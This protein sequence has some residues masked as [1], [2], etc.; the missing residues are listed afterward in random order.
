[1]IEAGTCKIV[2]SMPSAGGPVKTIAEGDYLR[3]SKNGHIP[4]FREGAA[5]E[6]QVLPRRLRSC[7]AGHAGPDQIQ[8]RTGIYPEPHRQNHQP[9][10][11]HTTKRRNNEGLE[12]A[13][14]V[15]MLA[16]RDRPQINI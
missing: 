3:F 14:G 5:S 6:A 16:S 11:N 8:Q 4:S 9:K 7:E 2:Y 13:L 12:V 15:G 10:Q 1:V